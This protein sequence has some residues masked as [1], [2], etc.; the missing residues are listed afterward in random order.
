MKPLAAEFTY[1]PV[2]SASSGF[3]FSAANCWRTSPAFQYKLYAQKYL[4]I[5][6][7]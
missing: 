1:L 2:A 6:V 5:M 3:V 4:V 7:K